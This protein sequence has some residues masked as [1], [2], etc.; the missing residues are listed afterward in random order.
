MSNGPYNYAEGGHFALIL[1]KP[2]NLWFYPYITWSSV[3]RGEF[4]RGGKSGQ[5]AFLHSATY[6]REM[7]N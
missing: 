7:I 5:V 1:S 3:S 6:P 4:S 2:F